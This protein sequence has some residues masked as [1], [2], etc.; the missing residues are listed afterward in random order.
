MKPKVSIIIPVYNVEKYVQRMLACIEQ[1]TL[2]D[3]EAIIINDG[4]TDRSLDIIEAFCKDNDRFHVYTQEN[5]GVSAARNAGLDKAKGEYVTFYDPDDEVP[6]NALQ[7]LCDTM[8]KKSADLVIGVL[9]TVEGFQS[10]YAGMIRKLA[11]TPKISRY[12]PALAANFSLANKLFRREIIEKYHLRF[13]DITY[14]ED[15][16]FVFHY[17]THCENLA[18][19]NRKV[20]IYHLRPFWD[21][22]SITQ[23]IRLN[24]LQ[25][26]LTA[27]RLT[28]DRL[29][30]KIAEDQATL[31]AMQ[32]SEERFAKVAKKHEILLQRF[33]RR[34]ISRNLIKGFYARIWRAQED[35]HP[36]LTDGIEEL[37]GEISAK[38]WEVIKQRHPELDL[39]HPL[40]TKAEIAANPKVTFV[41][42]EQVDPKQLPMI[43]KGMYY[44]EMPLFEVMIAESLRDAVPEIYHSIENVRFYSQTDGNVIDQAKGEYVNFVREHVFHT[45][46]CLTEMYATLK[47]NPAID[48]S[49][50][51]VKQIGAEGGVADI[52]IM[53][54]VYKGQCEAQCGLNIDRLDTCISNK[55]FRKEALQ[56]TGLSILAFKGDETAQIYESMSYHKINDRYMVSYD[57]SDALLLKDAKKLQKLSDREQER[58]IGRKR[59]AAFR[60]VYLP[61]YYKLQCLKPVK[62]KKVILLE[63]EGPLL[64]S[65]LE[66]IRQ[67]LSKDPE[68]DIRVFFVGDKR[69]YVLR[70]KHLLAEIADT[71]KI[72][73][74]MP[75]SLQHVS[76]RKDT[77]LISLKSRER[78]AA[79]MEMA[80]AKSIRK[81]LSLRCP[82][83]RKQ[84]LIFLNVGRTL[85][86]KELEKL[87]KS[88]RK[89][90]I[91]LLWN[92]SEHAYLNLE[93]FDHQVIHANA[94]LTREEAIS[95]SSAVISCRKTDI[96]MGNILDKD[97]VFFRKEEL[98][99]IGNLIAC[100]K[101]K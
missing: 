23:S 36:V 26:A 14:S 9:E 28:G 52:P 27:Y 91:L 57:L 8:E 55:L 98:D 68:M 34:A 61:A 24:I 56:R 78:A 101:K 46:N 19:C 16:A 39:D 79:V 89:N 59:K 42:T 4:S 2:Q 82:Q 13:D 25:D 43:L 32:V 95:L 51:E 17:I 20:Y 77:E 18:G 54:R 62:E 12:H 85:K 93:P 71:A 53:S 30:A 69:N 33:Y 66:R 29:K 92:T 86:K 99:K 11:A 38:N 81:K 31:R 94:F 7:D 74:N 76:L 87:R 84:K 44:Q 83:V 47:H 75:S 64:S 45:Y 96:R 40:P 10:R 41:V 80:D 73:T 72:Y 50:V 21:N 88:L 90:R 100:I 22:P 48:F 37:K 65:G 67:N 58:V 1:Q 63:G 60:K 5:Q 97:S 3:F 35:I 70:E 15:G 6:P 49:T